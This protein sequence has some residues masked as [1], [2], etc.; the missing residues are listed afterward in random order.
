MPN[1]FGAVVACSSFTNLQ[2][3]LGLS[4]SGCQVGDRIVSNFS[5]LF[6]G[7]TSSDT[8]QSP[9]VPSASNVTVTTAEA[10]QSA[11]PAWVSLTFNFNGLATVAANQTMS[12]TIQYVV[13]SG[14]AAPAM[15]GVYMNGVGA[16]RNQ[17]AAD[18]YAAVT[19]TTCL[20][21][22]Y[23][24]AAKAP[25][26]I[27]QNGT[28][29]G[30]L[31]DEFGATATTNNPN[32]RGN[33]FTDAASIGSAL[34]PLGQTKVGV[35]TSVELMGGSTDSPAG[36]SEAA[37]STLTQTFYESYATPEPVPLV[38]VGCALVGLSWGRRQKAR[39]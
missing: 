36:A 25:T 26:G 24:Q 31:D 2:Q 30:V 32:V 12:L 6:Q 8:A 3:Y 22:S 39:G 29:A 27:C 37:L 4:S 10:S 11:D 7:G 16:E 1:A 19:G 9:L 35:Y 21:G 13:T 28:Q 5:F 18:A 15:E 20:G 23:K 33:Q 14:V 17:S 38:L 34:A